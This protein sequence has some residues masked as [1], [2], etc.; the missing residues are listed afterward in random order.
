MS[1]SFVRVHLHTGFSR[2]DGMTRTPVNLAPTRSF[3]SNYGVTSDRFTITRTGTVYQDWAFA[4]DL[5]DGA[6]DDPMLDPNEDGVLNIEHYA[7]DTAPLGGG[8]TEGKQRVGFVTKGGPRHFALTLPIRKGAIFYGA[9]ALVTG[10]NGIY[11]KL[12][13]SADLQD[14]TQSVSEYLPTAAA[15]LPTLRDI[16]G[17]GTPDWEYRTFILDDDTLP[18][19]FLRTATALGPP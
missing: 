14:W 7:F 19:G 10:I 6:D 8:G 2:L 1:D 17:D 9:P 3:S 5:T 4:S 11:V 12:Q 18:H 16:D 13:G 15:G